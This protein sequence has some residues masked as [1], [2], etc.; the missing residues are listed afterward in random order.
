MKGFVITSKLL[1]RTYKHRME[2]NYNVNFKQTHCR[3]YLLN[4]VLF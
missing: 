4:Q 1:L 2:D 3:F